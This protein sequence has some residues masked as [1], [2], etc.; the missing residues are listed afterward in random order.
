M[1][2]VTPAPVPIINTFE[3]GSE[4]IAVIGWLIPRLKETPVVNLTPSFMGW[5]LN[6]LPSLVPRAMNSCPF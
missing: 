6:T 2:S 4:A 1:K 3:L 5:T